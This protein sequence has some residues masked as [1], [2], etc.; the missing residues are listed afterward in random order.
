MTVTDEGNLL[1]SEVLNLRPD[2]RRRYPDELRARILEWL[3]RATKS[4]WTDADCGKV[5]GIQTYRFQLWRR[6]Q[7]AA[8]QRQET[9]ALVR[10]ETEQVTSASSITLITPTS[11]RVEGLMF[12]ELLRLLRELA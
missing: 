5:L 12:E 6:E 10:V 3:T 9:T 7:R 8:I 4:G 1:R 11:Y 2:K